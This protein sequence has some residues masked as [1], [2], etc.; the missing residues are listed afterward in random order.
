LT[1]DI[2][3]PGGGLTLA[4]PNFSLATPVV[5]HASRKISG[6]VR[7]AFVI[8]ISINVIDLCLCPIDTVNWK[9]V[10]LQLKNNY[11]MQIIRENNFKV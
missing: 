6:V 7:I 2:L 11:N 5:C 3:P 1:F 10:G 8:K 9:M 4:T